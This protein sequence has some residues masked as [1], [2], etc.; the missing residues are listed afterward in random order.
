MAIN[1]DEARAA[2]AE[3][4]KVHPTLVFAGVEYELPLELPLPLVTNLKKLADASKKKDGDAVTQALLDSMES[5]LGARYEEFMAAGPSVND[6]SVIV[7]GI[8]GE[9]GLGLG[10]A[11]ASP[12]RSKNTTA[13]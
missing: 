11:S 5:L 6:L 10:E 7:E 9:Y 1:L 3:A 13:R 4:T 2:R 8:P 12:K